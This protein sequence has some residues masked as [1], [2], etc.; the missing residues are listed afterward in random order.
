MLEIFSKGRKSETV[1]VLSNDVHETRQSVNH[2]ALQHLCRIKR[3]NTCNLFTNTS[4]AGA[5]AYF[6]GT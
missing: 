2:A 5:S 3:S 4:P 6:S 1:L